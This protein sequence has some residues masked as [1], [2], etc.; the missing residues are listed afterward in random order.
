MSFAPL[1]SVIIPVY[2]G[3]NYISKTIRSVYNQTYTNF[4]III[5]NDG[6]T[7]D[8]LGV[9]EKEFYD[10]KNLHVY[11]NNNRGVSYSRNYGMLQ[12]TGDIIAL[13]DADD[14][15]YSQNLEKKI[16]ILNSNH[17]IDFTFSNMGAIDEN[18]LRL[19]DPEIG[20]GE[21]LF[22]NILFWNGEVIPGPCSNL[23]FRRKILESISFNEN[24]STAADQYFTLELSFSY[25][26]VFIPEKTWDYRILSTSMS[27]NIKVMEK[28][29][30]LIIELV[31]SKKWIGNE[32]EFQLF[33]STV[34]YIVGAS[35]WSHGRNFIKTIQILLEAFL[36]SPIQILNKMFT[37]IH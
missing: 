36:V 3:R 16:N 18:D 24:L 5:I 28:D 6:S 11:T 22:K 27:K 34:L 32:R 37:K 17:K 10:R 35:Y 8:T 7:D 31:K 15:W 9:I 12:A 29:H 13:L 26:G 30:R 19:Q 4:E 14:I 20:K 2:N 33:K 1:V 25:N 23:V 21:N